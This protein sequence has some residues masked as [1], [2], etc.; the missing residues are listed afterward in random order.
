MNSLPIVVSVQPNELSQSGHTCETSISLKKTKDHYRCRR[1]PLM[2]PP[3][4]LPVPP[5][6]LPKVTTILTNVTVQ[7]FLFLKFIKMESCR[8]CFFMSG[9]LKNFF[10]FLIY[11]W[12]CW[13]FITVRG[14]SLVAVS[15][16]YS[17]LQC[18]GFSLRWLLL[19]WSTGCRHKG[20]SICGVRASVVVAHGLSCSAACGIFPGQ[21]SNPRCLQ[22]QADS[23]P[24]RHQG[25]LVICVFK[26]LL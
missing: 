25:S 20:F 23:S 11:F 22:C 5:H 16:G 14:L 9:F 2:P 10:I 7:F 18:T 8:L 21:G 6:P 3:A 17:S 12:P 15:G 19:L 4:I 1:R 24:L 13:V 26:E